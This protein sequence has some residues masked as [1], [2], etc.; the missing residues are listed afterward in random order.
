MFLEPGGATRCGMEPPPNL[1]SG[2][3]NRLS[4]AARPP[5]RILGAGIVMKCLLPTMLAL[6]SLAGSCTGAKVPVPSSAS[7]VPSVTVRLSKPQNVTVQQRGG[8]IVV[9]P[10][11]ER[12]FVHAIVDKGS[13]V[14]ARLNPGGFHYV[15][16][17]VSDAGITLAITCADGSK[18]R[19]RVIF[20]SDST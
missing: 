15:V 20:V 12:L 4:G 10:E 6:G 9:E 3:N 14:C 19:V 16:S 17:D 8:R 11:S 5:G 18:H 1:G 7:P 13:A 2:A